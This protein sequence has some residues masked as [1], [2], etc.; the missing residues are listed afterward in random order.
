MDDEFVEK[1]RQELDVLMKS[2]A[3]HTILKNDTQLKAFLTL[4]DFDQYKSNP[5]AFEKVMELY[6]Y[7]P[8][9]RKLSLNAIPG[10]I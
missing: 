2:I 10:V 1:R 3:A 4:P 7:L 5:S 8:S 6:E 9:I